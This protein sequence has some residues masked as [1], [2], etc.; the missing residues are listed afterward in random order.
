MA[1]SIRANFASCLSDSA[2]SFFTDS[3]NH[4]ARYVKSAEGRDKTF[5][6]IDAILDTSSEAA[7]AANASPDAIEGIGKGRVW[8]KTCRDGF[9]FFNIFSGKIAAMVENLKDFWALTRGKEVTIPADPK[10]GESAKTIKADKEYLRERGFS[11]A[12]KLGSGVALAAYVFGFGVCRPI[13]NINNYIRDK[14][15]RALIKMGETTLKLGKAFPSVMLVNHLA[16]LIGFSCELAYRKAAFDRINDQSDGAFQTFVNS[17]VKITLEIIEKFL[18]ILL[19]I[20]TL[21]G[22]AIPAWFRLPLTLGIGL[23][24]CYKEWHAV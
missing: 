16:G 17:V 2:K 3:K 5:K 4:L 14:E 13:T 12:A 21:I 10:T 1:A 15:G 6:L 19:D 9:A 11:A 18:D 20:V 8:V 23:L 7:K 22:Q 24:G